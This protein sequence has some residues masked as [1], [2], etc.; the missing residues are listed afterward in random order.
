MEWHDFEARIGAVRETD[1]RLDICPGQE[2]FIGD[3]RGGFACVL[4]KF[5]DRSVVEGSVASIGLGAGIKIDAVEEIR[6]F[7]VFA[8]QTLNLHMLLTIP[9]G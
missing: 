2:G 5:E 6:G 4:K 9:R 8:E 7:G 3:E 1:D